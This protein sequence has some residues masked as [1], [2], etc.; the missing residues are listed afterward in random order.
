M[1]QGKRFDRE[2]LVFFAEAVLCSA[3]DRIESG[4]PTSGI[5]WKERLH[6]ENCIDQNAKTLTSWDRGALETAGMA[7]AVFYAQ[8]TGD[9]LAICDALACA[10]S[11]DDAVEQWV[12]TTWA[13]EGEAVRKRIDDLCSSQHWPISNAYVNYPDCRRHAEAFVDRVF[14]EYTQTGS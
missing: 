5:D 2:Q 11:F 4:M 14:T 7:L 6:Y 13:D 3:L 1:Y 8:L 9:G 12:E 10:D